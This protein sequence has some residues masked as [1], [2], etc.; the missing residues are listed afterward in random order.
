MTGVYRR[1]HWNPEI[2]AHSDRAPSGQ[3]HVG[4]WD[5]SEEILSEVRQ[6]TG[7]HH[8]VLSP[9]LPMPHVEAA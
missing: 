8:S 2:I 1:A 7:L 5:V 3:V 6:A 9:A 4:L